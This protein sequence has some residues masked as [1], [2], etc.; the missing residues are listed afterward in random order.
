M[1]SCRRC[2]DFSIRTEVQSSWFRYLYFAQVVVVVAAVAFVAVV[3]VDTKNYL[4]SKKF[5]IINFQLENEYGSYGLQTGNCDIVY[6][7]HLRDLARLYLGN[8]VVLYTTDG[9]G[10]DYLRCYLNQ[11]N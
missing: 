4:K 2:S 1:S 6:M 5:Q 9:N 7:T 8:D 11:S 10:D 3:A